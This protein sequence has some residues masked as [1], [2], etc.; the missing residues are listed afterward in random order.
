MRHKLGFVFQGCEGNNHYEEFNSR[1]EAEVRRKQLNE[2]FGS[3]VYVW[4]VKEE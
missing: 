1:E 2:Q 3:Y 4:I